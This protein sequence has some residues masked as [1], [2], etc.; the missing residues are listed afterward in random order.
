M[1]EP[2]DFFI[3]FLSSESIVATIPLWIFT[4]ETMASSTDLP[5]ILIFL[6]LL[7]NCKAS[8]AEVFF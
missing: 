6:K 5:D 7:V 2:P 4:Y 3:L 1:I 8:D